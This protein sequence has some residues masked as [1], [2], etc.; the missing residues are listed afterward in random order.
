[1][2]THRN[3][4]IIARLFREL[5]GLS[6]ETPWVEFKRNNANPEDIGEYISALANSCALL[7][8]PKGY[9]LWGVEDGTHA[10]VGTTFSPHVEKKGN[11]ALENWLH[12]LLAPAVHF[13][14]FETKVEGVPVVVLEVE[15]AQHQ[16]VAFQG[17][18]YVRVGSHKKK[19]KD[20]PEKERALWRTF[21][22]TPFEEG[23][24][25]GDLD[26][27][28]L[29]ERLDHASYFA[30][31]KQRVP[32]TRAGV[33]QALQRERLVHRA[34]N[35]RWNITNAA[36]LLFA[37]KLDEFPSLRRKAMR[38]IEY[39]GT[40][41]IRTRREQVG[42]R[43][44]ATGFS[45]LIEFILAIV[46]TNEEI[47]KALRK[48]VPMYPALAIRELVAN[49]LIHQDFVPTG[50]GPTVEIFDDRIEITNPGT[51]LVEVERFL[52]NPPRSRNEGM[53]S[54][55][56]RMGIC[57]ER[58]SG[59]DK[60]VFEVEFHQL[61]APLFEV[62]GAGTR[63][64]L[65]AHRALTKMDRDDRVRAC[66]LHACLR[67]VSREYLTNASLRQRFAIDER[68][69]AIASRL[70]KEAIEDGKIVPEDEEASRKLMR[71]VPFWAAPRE[72]SR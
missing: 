62:V 69:S 28:T 1:M 16:P 52:D 37:K 5:V 8:K 6:R 42:G 65:F 66:Y 7:D 40:N 29:A 46:P 21:D 31:T 54:L 36:A 32:D 48:S 2:N 43:G 55:M 38:V 45:G 58:G 20:F 23:I 47:E 44:Y 22:R 10:I 9:V 14:F 12:R 25:L 41:R 3:H 13:E 70:I 30:L 67:Y 26:D 72:L 53:A 68:N 71:Y 59:I 4:D 18:E 57:E 50:T 34:A 49:A 33:I 61:P 24:A 27:E 64:V 17:Q 56:R 11:E 15:R 35:G 51:P 19:L 39:D 63:S 60:V